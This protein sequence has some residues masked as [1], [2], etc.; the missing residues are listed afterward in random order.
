MLYA[1][2][3]KH[4]CAQK[5]Q[6][7]IVNET[8]AKKKET[9]DKKTNKNAN[10]GLTLKQS[11]GFEKKDDSNNFYEIDRT[12]EDVKEEET[13]IW[14]YIKYIYELKKKEL[15]CTMGVNLNM[16]DI[17]EDIIKLLVLLKTGDVYLKRFCKKLYEC[18]LKRKN[19]KYTTSRNISY[20]H[21]KKIYINNIYN[22]NI[23]N[24]NFCSRIINNKVYEYKVKYN[25]Q[26]NIA[27][28]QQFDGTMCS[29]RISQD[30]FFYFTT[31]N[32]NIFSPSEMVSNKKRS[33]KKIMDTICFESN[34]N[35]NN[36]NSSYI[37]VI[38]NN[39]QSNDN[40]SSNGNINIEVIDTQ[41]ETNNIIKFS[42]QKQPLRTFYNNNHLFLVNLLNHNNK[43]GCNQK[44]YFTYSIYNNNDKEP[45]QL[46]YISPIHPM[47]P[48]IIMNE[49][50]YEQ[51]SKC[52]YFYKQDKCFIWTDESTDTDFSPKE[53]SKLNQTPNLN[54]LHINE[55][56]PICIAF[57][58]I[59]ESYFF[60]H[61]VYTIK[62]HNNS[63]SYMN[64]YHK[65]LKNN[66]IMLYHFLS[67]KKMK[68]RFENELYKKINF[69]TETYKPQ[70]VL[71]T[72]GNKPINN[73]IK[74]CLYDN[75]NNLLFLIPIYHKYVKYK[76]KI[77]KDVLNFVAISLSQELLLLKYYP[78]NICAYVNN[79]N[80]TNYL[81]TRYR[82]M[83]INSTLINVCT[84]DANTKDLKEMFLKKKSILKNN[85]D[86]GGFY[87]KDIKN[88]SKSNKNSRSDCMG[89][90]SILDINKVNNF[91]II[92]HKNGLLY[93]LSD[94]RYISSV[95]L[96]KNNENVCNIYNSNLCNATIDTIKYG[97][98]K[99]QLNSYRVHFDI[100]PKSTTLKMIFIFFYYY[101]C[102]KITHD[103]FSFILY[104]CKRE[105]RKSIFSIINIDIYFF[106]HLNNH[107][108]ERGFNN[109]SENRGW[110]IHN[111]T[112]SVHD[113]SQSI[114]DNSQSI[115]DNSQSIRDN[116]QSIHDN[117]QSIHDNSQSIHDNSQ[118]IR[119]NSQ[120][121]HDKSQ[122]IHDNTQS[123]HD[124]SQNIHDKSQSIHDNSQNIHDNSQS[125]H[126]N[127]QSIHDNTQSIHDNTQSIHDNN[128]NTHNNNNQNNCVRN[129][130]SVHNTTF[131]KYDQTQ[132]HLLNTNFM[133]TENIMHCEFCRFMYLF[134]LVSVDDINMYM[135]LEKL[136]YI[137]NISYGTNTDDIITTEYK[138]SKFNGFS[139]N[140]KT[141]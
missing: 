6:G 128:S 122:S 132:F 22:T 8:E 53:C 135:N 98:N 39:H 86:V 100:L 40:S 37:Y 95:Y 7:N 45:I 19:K 92:L 67:I 5:N 31:Q 129:K 82:Y 60:F 61:M 89:N 12:K 105:E 79:Q 84:S 85:G 127:T 72:G 55:S 69:N 106:K 26:N 17:K 62:R 41:K 94:N 57:D 1:I 59:T 51:F 87:K 78:L 114:H 141:E 136:I 11:P 28:F 137:K 90:C 10:K 140:Y 124:N 104:E 14:R 34:N 83:D 4:V 29:F 109:D 46:M 70:V 66:Y 27:T 88:V 9:R 74:L 13:I 56:L 44:R 107:S 24:V 102:K 97:I 36:N 54:I 77:V 63:Y 38:S 110:R 111:S 76:I 120:S 117:S 81:N 125:I 71:T 15:Q 93:L 138:H 35:N 73:K 103:F 52:R 20:L 130:N 42:L 65:K 18:E 112:Q 116:S 23:Q 47:Y 96:Y 21:E 58:T 50:T 75:V 33:G 108:G 25:K 3:I 30:S 115:H 49:H 43:K 139:F 91:I 133:C 32:N 99:I 101:I 16:N 48:D 123:I 113:N 80:N 126:D 68:F 64:N 121:I 118:S 134:I 2:I 119:D 131:T